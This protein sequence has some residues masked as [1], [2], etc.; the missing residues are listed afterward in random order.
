MDRGQEVP[1]HGNEGLAALLRKLGGAQ[2]NNAG[3]P[4]FNGKYVTYF[5]FKKRGGHVGGFTML[6]LGASLSAAP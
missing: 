1:Q 2:A 3:W 5:R 4:L 6:T